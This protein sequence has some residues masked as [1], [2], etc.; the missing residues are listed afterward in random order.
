MQTKIHL[1]GFT[2]IEG[3]VYL[4]TVATVGLKIALEGEILK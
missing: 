1:N 2:I 3:L 4:A